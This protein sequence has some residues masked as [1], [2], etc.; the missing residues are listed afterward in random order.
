MCQ[1]CY[2]ATRRG[3]VPFFERLR[4]RNFLE[5]GVGIL[6]GAKGERWM[7][8][9]EDFSSTSC[10]LWSNSGS[11]YAETVVDGQKTY[12]HRLLMPRA[13]TIDHID[14]NPYNC[15]RHNL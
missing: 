6:T 8:T 7:V 14:R 15:L 12:L 1:R 9:L 5:N 13:K 2:Y 4:K 3:Q 11:G 10:Y